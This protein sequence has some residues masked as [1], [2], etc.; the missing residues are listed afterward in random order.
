MKIGYPC[1]NLSVGCSSSRTF[2]LASYSTARLK[3]TI[4]LNLDCLNQILRFN[5]ENGILF[6]RVS[7]DLVPFAS[8]PV[9]KFRWQDWFKD[10]FGML[11]KFIRQNHIRISM[12]PDQFVLLNSPRQE[13]VRNSIRELEYHA[14]LLD[15]M[16]L[17]EA[18]K[19]QIHIGGR[20]DDKSVSMER[21]VK[22][23]LRLDPS[24]R[25]RLVIENDDRLYSLADCIKVHKETGIPVLFDAFHHS[26]QNN[27]ESISQALA[28][29]AGTWKKRDGL[30]MVDYSR[31]KPRGR[32]GAH[33]ESVDPRLFKKFLAQTMPFDFDLMLEIKDK[34]KSALKAIKVASGDP[35]YDKIRKG[36]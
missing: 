19:I 1:V 25:N 8:H 22:T 35:R 5:V 27:R 9:C 4:A 3:E 34:E 33:A 2:R 28:M 11:G 23:W 31:Q 13:V 32:P 7:S 16:E 10:E 21:F 12:H 36:R 26:L 24:I 20:Y 14:R 6:F 30:P 17:D 18:A 15:L 29:S